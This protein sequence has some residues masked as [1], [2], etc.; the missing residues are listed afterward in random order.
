ML[1]EDIIKWLLLL[2]RGW[3]V[4]QEIQ[5]VMGWGGDKRMHLHA[6]GWL[7]NSTHLHVKESGYARHEPHYKLSFRALEQVN[8]V[9]GGALSYDQQRV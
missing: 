2:G 6:I 9:H 5:R 7:D 3:V 1:N 4:R 8:K